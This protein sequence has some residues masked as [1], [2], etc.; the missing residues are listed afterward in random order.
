MNLASMSA[1]AL[2]VADLYDQVNQ[3]LL[4]RTWTRVDYAMGFV[5]DVGDLMKIIQ[6]IEGIRVLSGTAEELRL[7]PDALEDL[8]RDLQHELADGLWSLLVL[9]HLSGVDLYAAFTTF[10]TR[11]SD[12]LKEH[13]EA[14]A[15]AAPEVLWSVQRRGVEQHG[16]SPGS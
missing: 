8:Q 14:I 11:E 15:A 16:S 6:R 7:T 1:D 13:L 10:I 5:G 3:Q 2:K 4:G 9:S 12:R